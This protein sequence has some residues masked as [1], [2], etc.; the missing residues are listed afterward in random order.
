MP[1]TS[2]RLS[3]N[4][5][6]TS[7]GL[8]SGIA[9]SAGAGAYTYTNVS[10]LRDER[11]AQSRGVFQPHGGPS[12][13]DDVVTVWSRALGW[14]GAPSDQQGL[15]NQISAATGKDDGVNSGQS[16]IASGDSSSPGDSAG[17]A[18]SSQTNSGQDSSSSSSQS[19]SSS[20]STSLPGSGSSDQA[21]DVVISGASTADQVGMDESINENHAGRKSV[22]S[23]SDGSDFSS[24]E[25]ELT[26]LRNKRYTA[27]AQKRIA[28][29]GLAFETAN[30]PL[31]QNPFTGQIGSNPPPGYAQGQRAAK[32]S[33]ARAIS[34]GAIRIGRPASA[35]RV[36]SSEISNT[37]PTPPSAEPSGGSYG[38]SSDHSGRSR[39]R[40]EG[41]INESDVGAPRRPSGRAAVSESDSKRAGISSEPESP[42]APPKPAP[43]KP[44]TKK[45][46][47]RVD[48]DVP[49]DKNE[50]GN[51]KPPS[52]DGG[53]SGGGYNGS[54]S[55]SGDG[56]YGGRGFT[57]YEQTREQCKEE[58]SKQMNKNLA[59]GG[60]RQGAAWMM[61]NNIVKRDDGSLGVKFNANFPDPPISCSSSQTRAGMPEVASS[62]RPGNDATNWLRVLVGENEL[63]IKYSELAAARAG[64][65]KAQQ[66]YLAAKMAPL[67]Y[68]KEQLARDDLDPKTVEQLVLERNVY[69]EVIGLLNE[70][71]AG[72]ADS[73]AAIDLD[74]LVRCDVLAKQT[75]FKKLLQTNF[76][77]GDES[78]E[79]VL[80][81]L[82]RVLK[83]PEPPKC[84]VLDSPKNPTSDSDV[85]RVEGLYT[86]IDGFN[87]F[88][89]DDMAKIYQMA[90]GSNLGGYGEFSQALIS[91]SKGHQ[92][93]NMNFNGLLSKNLLECTDSGSWGEWLAAEEKKVRSYARECK[94]PQ[95]RQFDEASGAMLKAA[96]CGGGDARKQGVA[97]LFDG[98]S[99]VAEVVDSGGDGFGG[100]RRGPGAFSPMPN[101]LKKIENDRSDRTRGESDRVQSTGRPNYLLEIGMQGLT[102]KEPDSSTGGP[103]SHGN[104]SAFSA[105][106]DEMP[107]I[108]WA[109]Q[110]EE[111]R[112]RSLEKDSF[113]EVRTPPPLGIMSCDKVE[114][115][116][117][118][119]LGLLTHQDSKVYTNVVDSGLCDRH[120]RDDGNS[121]GHK[122]RGVPGSGGSG[123]GDIGDI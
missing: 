38:L 45:P 66:A 56:G 60:N 25:R 116:Y 24:Q 27:D 91:D 7:L 15:S 123:R 48:P 120:I 110:K 17:S 105:G 119:L 40:R 5:R 83:A 69:H 14:N 50:T 80:T 111:E 84:S 109:A 2:K 112:L 102:Q 29:N 53:G 107:D 13:V 77:V 54:G 93:D 117:L 42:P 86:M 37:T 104:S 68:I 85:A 67:K 1:Y 61:A 19:S 90:K 58:L 72:Y 41:Y 101:G 46:K 43:S 98:S 88:L 47:E 94:V 78:P 34:P 39:S 6:F 118:F 52:N 121:S 115:R 21:S 44:D 30:G 108:D 114:R 55:S 18:S 11:A 100:I 16:V 73:N 106:S 35:G 36:P 74:E 89:G 70:E 99:T 49:W 22:D 96:F 12:V 122:K 64:G 9:L 32:T 8:A 79:C 3:M 31:Y 28:K 71:F 76:L 10:E 82:G 20:T 26:A 87:H 62:G 57:G 59:Q 4:V 113:I 103:A 51:P 97:F 75:P 65:R 81:D 95:A 63:S 23:N 33:G 92:S